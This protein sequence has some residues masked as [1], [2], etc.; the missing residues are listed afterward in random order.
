MTAIDTEPAQGP[1]TIA[2]TEYH[3]LA[4]DSTGMLL[5]SV[6]RAI[7]RADTT[8]QALSAQNGKPYSIDRA[9]HELKPVDGELRL[10]CMYYFKPESDQDGY[11]DENGQF[12][13]FRL[14]R[15]VVDD[16]TKANLPIVAHDPNTWKGS[17]T[18]TPLADILALKKKM[19]Q[20]CFPVDQLFWG[21][22]HGGLWAVPAGEEETARQADPNSF[23]VPDHWRRIR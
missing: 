5:E 4:D 8:R 15:Q 18:A 12:V 21:D 19:E 9:Q 1:D 14:L 20:Y 22:C 16:Y 23:A 7:G 3:V 6:E 2:F 17:T 13:P 10:Y 11:I